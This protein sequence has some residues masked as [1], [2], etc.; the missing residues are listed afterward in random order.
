[1]RELGSLTS[2]ISIFKMTN[3]NEKISSALKEKHFWSIR[4]TLG[5]PI[6][7]WTWGTEGLYAID[8]TMI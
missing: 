3:T 1:M 8:M 4:E 5:M 2:D 6:S 7:Q